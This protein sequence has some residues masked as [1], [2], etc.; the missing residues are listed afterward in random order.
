MIGHLLD[1]RMVRLAKKTKC[2]YSRYVDDLTFSTNNKKFP[3]E[4]AYCSDGEWIPGDKLTGE[5][6]SVGFKINKK[7]TSMQYKLLR[8]MVTGLVVNRK[9]NIKKEYYKSARAACYNLFNNGEF[10]FDNNIFRCNG[11]DCFQRRLRKLE[12]ILSYIYYIKKQSF[13]KN[14]KNEEKYQPKSITKLYRQFLCYKYFYCTDKPLIICEGK[15]DITYLKCALKQLSK[16][17]GNLIERNGEEYNFKIVFFPF[18]KNNKDVFNTPEG[19]TGQRRIM[20]A[21]EDNFKIFKDK[22][23]KYPVIILID[24]DRG[25]GPVIGKLPKKKGKSNMP[26]SFYH[27]KGNMYVV[28]IPKE[29]GQKD[30]PIEDLFDKETLG[31]KVAGRSFKGC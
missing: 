2:T 6:D 24:N 30:T 28:E 3:K 4:I 31:T 14:K 27:F 11:E 17:Y 19:T 12:G 15:T 25:S 23:E 13:L 8:Q 26:K 22:A 7:K 1:V 29:P 10:Y 9:V 21:Y 20:E 16:K 18:S 5:V